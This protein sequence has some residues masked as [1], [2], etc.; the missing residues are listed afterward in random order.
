[1]DAVLETKTGGLGRSFNIR[2]PVVHHP[3]RSI[4]INYRTTDRKNGSKRFEYRVKKK[5]KGRKEENT[6][7]L[8]DRFI[9]R[10]DHLSLSL[11]PSFSVAR[12]IVPEFK[13]G[14]QVS[15]RMINKGSGRRFL[16]LFNRSRPPYPYPA[17]LARK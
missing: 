10:K 11:S 2:P 8:P 5:K 9:R 12:S 13:L 16:D 15:A 1:M 6:T 3:A 17:R 14:V 7:I 4:N